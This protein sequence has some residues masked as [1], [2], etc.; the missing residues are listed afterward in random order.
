MVIARVSFYP[1]RTPL[2]P[3]ICTMRAGVSGPAYLAAAGAPRRPE[4]IAVHRSI[5]FTPLPWRDSRQF[6]SKRIA[7]RPRLLTDNTESLRAATL[8]GAGLAA[9]PA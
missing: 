1:T 2:L 7:M 4:E 8:A 3:A 6:G 5:G 9:L